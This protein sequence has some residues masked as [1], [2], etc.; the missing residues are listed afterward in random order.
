MTERERKLAMFGQAVL[1]LLAREEYWDGD[2]IDPSCLDDIIDNA[3]DSGLAEFE[4]YG[5]GE[6]KLKN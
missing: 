1:N 4:D 5:Q 6:F 2:I 3:I